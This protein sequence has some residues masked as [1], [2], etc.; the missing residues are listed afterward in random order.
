VFSVVISGWTSL[1]LFS[2]TKFKVEIND[3]IDK[4]YLNQKKFIFNIR[5]LSILLLKDAN[6][7]FSETKP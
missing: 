3:L 4:M 1:V 6:E 7:R 2:N 5:D